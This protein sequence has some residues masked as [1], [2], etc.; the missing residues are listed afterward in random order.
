M[1]GARPVVSI[2]RGS[3]RHEAVVREKSRAGGT[4]EIQPG[5]LDLQGQV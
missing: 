5:S 3:Q 1:R 4:A 2:K